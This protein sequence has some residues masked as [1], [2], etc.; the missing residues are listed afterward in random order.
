LL[1][2]SW[3]QLTGH[4]QARPYDFWKHKKARRACSESGKVEAGRN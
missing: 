2:P 4:E 1:A 3:S